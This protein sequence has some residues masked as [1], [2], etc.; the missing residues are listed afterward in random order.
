[1][2]SG[3]EGLIAI[4]EPMLARTTALLHEV[5]HAVVRQSGWNAPQGLE[6]GLA[7]YFAGAIYLPNGRV[8]L[9]G[10]ASARISRLR[11]SD[12]RHLV[13]SLNWLDE[14]GVRLALG[15][16][17]AARGYDANWAAAHWLLRASGASLSDA[18]AWLTPAPELLRRME[19]ELP[20]WLPAAL[21]RTWDAPA[22][23]EPAAG[24]A[25]AAGQGVREA[26][27]IR[28]LMQCNQADAAQR[29]AAELKLG[30]SAENALVHAALGRLAARLGRW[31]EAVAELERATAQ[32]VNDSS[33]WRQL[34]YAYGRLGRQTAV[35]AALQHVLADNP[36]DDEAR[37]VRASILLWIGQTDEGLQ[38]LNRIA[39]AP[40]GR[41][42]EFTQLVA[43]GQS[44]ERQQ[45]AIVARRATVS[46]AAQ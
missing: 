7:E 27:M 42:A 29:I 13:N 18:G 46:G 35:A 41:E 38:E 20:A 24:T 19:R 14:T 21:N 34:A 30:D 5:F 22:P 12:L 36:N 6:E 32:G 17:E 4:R 3:V 23:A 2:Q 45:H 9:G 39:Q 26:T 31:D 10:T 16:E 28:I 25:R 11:S 15:S 43:Q 37:M 8:T 44:I 1:V 33:T 40:K